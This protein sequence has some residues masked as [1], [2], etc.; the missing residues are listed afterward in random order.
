MQYI[1]NDMDE[2]FNKAGRDYPLKTGTGDWDAVMAQLQQ[3]DPAMLPPDR[4]RNNNR[5]YWLL[6]LLL[7]P[8]A[9]F[10]NRDTNSTTA[11]RGGERTINVKEENVSRGAAVAIKPANKTVVPADATNSLKPAGSAAADSRIAAGNKQAGA[12]TQKH[13]LDEPTSR[14]ATSR[15]DATAKRQAASSNQDKQPG[16][17][18]TDDPTSFFTRAAATTDPLSPQPPD[19]NVSPMEPVNPDRTLNASLPHTLTYTY[20][21]SEVPVPPFQAVPASTRKPALRFPRLYAGLLAGPD[22]SSIK[23]QRIEKAGF[24]AGILV[25]YRINQRWSAE[26]GLLYNKKQYYTD[27]QYFNKT[28]ANIP[29]RVTIDYLDGSCG[30]LE[31]PINIRYN[32]F[33]RRNG[34]FVTA[35]ATT[36]FMQKEEYVYEAEAGGSWYEGHR[37]YNNSGNHFFANLQFSGG[38]QYS[39]SGKTSLRIEPYFKIPI[40]QVGIGNIPITS[41]GVYLGIQR[42]IR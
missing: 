15:L 33:R 19:P 38:Y 29:D 6:L 27:G 17:L 22:L 24:S 4:P 8:L 11:A 16:S 40:K 1:D 18:F 2:L 42:T 34:F 36:Y 3:P 26:A 5:R 23:Q 13:I 7:L 32:L 9:F 25:G 10:L 31:L 20:P 30:M 41:T 35:G 21:P 37:T 28:R 14:S 12:G 39:L